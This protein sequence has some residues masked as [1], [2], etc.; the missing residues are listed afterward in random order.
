[1]YE[2]QIKT[3]QE[4]AFFGMCHLSCIFLYIH[5]LTEKDTVLVNYKIKYLYKR[6]SAIVRLA[7]YHSVSSHS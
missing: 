6:V 7:A 5:V 3:K 2:M 4:M 1:M